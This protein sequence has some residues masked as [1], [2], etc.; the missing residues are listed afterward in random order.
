MFC[1]MFFKLNA[2]IYRKLVSRGVLEERCKTRNLTTMDAGAV[3]EI[4]G[5]QLVDT[6]YGKGINL[7]IVETKAT[8]KGMKRQTSKLMISDRFEPECEKIPCIG[9]YVGSKSTKSGNKCHD[10]RF[11]KHDDDSGIFHDSDDDADECS[12]PPPPTPTTLRFYTPG[13]C[14]ICEMPSDQCFGFCSLCNEHIP[15]GG[16]QHQCAMA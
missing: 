8:A 3:F 9:Y 1:L 6:M 12:P 15:T 14:G 16:A 11:I 4:K 10:L 13:V 7:S 2:F 5:W